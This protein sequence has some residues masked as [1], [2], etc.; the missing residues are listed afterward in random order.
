MYLSR[1]HIDKTS[2][3]AKQ[4]LFKPNLVHGHVNRILTPDGGGVVD[5]RHIPLWRLDWLNGIPALYLVTKT[6]P[7]LN[8]AQQEWG[9]PGREPECHS[10]DKRLSSLSEGQEWSFRLTAN[11]TRRVKPR[12]GD[13]HTSAYRVA[14]RGPK[15]QREWLGMQGDRHGFSVLG[16][17]ITT[18]LK[19]YSFP[20]CVTTRDK[21]VLDTS[22]VT[23][24]SV[25]FTG[26]LEVTD[27]DKF[28]DALS[29]GIGRAKA[30]GCGLMTIAPA[31]A[32]R[33]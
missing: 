15:Y 1:L 22:E 4:Y 30:Y 8:A 25:T 24:G 14:H 5:D 26:R 12:E 11:P 7:D 19:M 10:Y 20:K 6:R 27:A 28:R 3:A 13:T 21:L 9:M 23:F 17:A 32:D 29:V 2:G 33:N 16:E 31:P 18:P